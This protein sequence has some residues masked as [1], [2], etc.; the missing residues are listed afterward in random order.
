[1]KLR[2]L[3]AITSV[4]RNDMAMKCRITQRRG[5][6]RRHI[7]RSVQDLGGVTIQLRD[8]RRLGYAEWGDPRGQP[9]VYFHGCPGSRAEGRVGDEAAKVSGIRV[10]APDRPGMGLSD[11][12]PRRA[13]IHWPD[14]VSQ[15]AEALGLERFAVLG[16]SGGSPYAAVCAWR[17][18]QR[19]IAAGIVSGI[20]PLDVPGVTEGMSRQNRLLFQAGRLPMLPRVV[21]GMTAVQARRPDRALEQGRRSFAPVDHLYLDRPELREILTASLAEAFRRGGRGP[22]WELRLY[23]RPW[24]FRLADIQMPVHLW[25]GERDTNDP[26]AM[27]RHLAAAI[28]DCRASFYPGEGH[29]HFVDRLP[30]ILRALCP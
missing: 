9:L 13:L 21:M 4:N 29:L 14:D 11:F 6:H 22:A 20:S 7:L 1:M 17:L 28:P 24:G 30:Q 19:L 3:L 25:H 26:I 2:T 15:V 10:I 5:A 12:Q 16:I 27:G 18:P 8:G 23:A